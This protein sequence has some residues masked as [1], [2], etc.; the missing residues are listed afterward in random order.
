MCGAVKGRYGYT[1][2]VYAYMHLWLKDGVLRCE[3]EGQFV[4]ANLVE[5][6]VV[7]AEKAPTSGRGRGV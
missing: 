2:G 3:K 7:L 1:K 6:V 5:R 4:S